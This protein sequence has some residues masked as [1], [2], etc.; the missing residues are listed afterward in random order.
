MEMNNEKL[1]R[2]K[3]AT[4]LA[5][6][7]GIFMS[8]LDS[9]VVYLAIPIIKNHFGVSISM[10]EWV[11]TAY[12][13]VLSSSVLTFGRLSDLYGHKKVYQAGLVIFTAASLLCGFSV[14]IAML[15]AFRVIQS[16]GASMVSATGPAIITNIV[17]P[18]S[19]GKGL[20]VTAISVAL[21]LVVGPV[22]GGTLSTFI[23]WQSIFFINVPIGILGFVIFRKNTTK[24]EKTTPIP[25]DIAGSI[26]IFIALLFILLPLS[27][28]GDYN[29]SAPLFISSIAAG[30]LLI[31]CFAVLEFRRKYPMLNLGLFKNKVFSGSNAAALFMYLAEFMMVFFV[32]F[33][34]ETLRGFSSLIAGVLFLPMPLA[35][36]CSAPISG[37]LSDRFDGRYFSSSGALIMAC[38]LFMLSFLNVNTALAYIIIAMFI[39]GLGFGMFQSPNNSAVMGNVPSGSRGIASGT[40]ATMKNI[41]MVLGVAVSGA[42]FSFYDSRA[43]Q[44]YALQGQSG[45]L[46]SNHSFAYALH[47][48]FI[49][50][51]GGALIAMIAPFIKGKVMTE[52]EKEN[53][54]R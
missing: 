8:S 22:V 2:I 40:L 5:V 32:P 18:E 36:M 39:T 4:L 1:Q 25:F 38:G 3:R 31:V 16:I 44:F 41:G 43:K 53:G 51:S 29:I 47:I 24:D 46:L 13:L 45:T 54:E 9:S 12:L 50:A 19:R 17:P 27:I 7:I 21:G 15:I 6:G 34:L 11:T 42:L 30:L 14:N 26:L 52:K 37:N 23:G 33:Y 48:T 28:S 10:I 20:S 35:T 49:T